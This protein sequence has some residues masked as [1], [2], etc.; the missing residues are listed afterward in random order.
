M[1]PTT[2]LLSSPS[3]FD[4]Q[5][6][7][8]NLKKIKLIS[9]TRIA[10]ILLEPKIFELAVNIISQDK[11]SQKIKA[12]ILNG[13]VNACKTFKGKIFIMKNMMP[14]LCEAIRG[15][16]VTI[17]ETFIEAIVRLSIACGA[18]FDRSVFIP[19]ESR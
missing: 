19:G 11:Y 18:Y 13:F 4:E 17:E 1:I 9:E 10:R 3:L 14:L 7:E 5:C 16:G 6:L 12:A 8:S 2:L 15:S